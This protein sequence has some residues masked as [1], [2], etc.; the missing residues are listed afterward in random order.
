[1]VLVSPGT[2]VTITDESFFSSAGPGTVPLIFIATKQDKLTSDG[3]ATA[4][5]STSVNADKLFLISS[6]RELLQTFGDPDFNVIGGL[7]QNGNPLNEYGL[8]AAYSYLGLANRAFVIRA[9]IDLNQL[10]PTAIEPTSDPA[11][12]TYWNYTNMCY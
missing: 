8:L 12:N 9:D 4:E 7:A 1:M 5:G 3:F 10:E 6:Q 2:Q 11:N